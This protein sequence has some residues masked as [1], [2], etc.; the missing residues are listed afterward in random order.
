MT[1]AKKGLLHSKLFLSLLGSV[2]IVLILGMLGISMLKPITQRLAL[3]EQHQN[4]MVPQADIVSLRDAV[5]MQDTQ[6][7]ALAEQHVQFGRDVVALRQKLGLPEKLEQ[8]L[9]AQHVE[10]NTLKDS[11]EALKKTAVPATQMS[12][13]P[14]VSAVQ[15][16]VHAATADI[17]SMHPDTPK[18]S[19]A[20]NTRAVRAATRS[21][22][23]VLTG[24]EQRGTTSFAAV[25]PKGFSDLSQVRLIGEGESFAGWALVNAGFRQA[26]FRVNGCLQTVSSQ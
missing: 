11:I 3:L 12:D 18:K 24:I 4:A 14:A 17:T 15:A 2:V 1:L 26:T 25:A 13:K 10:L 21:V 5:A 16:T 22:H 6:L 19:A 8:Q 23:F 9:Q 7:K 20:R